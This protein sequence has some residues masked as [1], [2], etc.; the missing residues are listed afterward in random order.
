MRGV[1]VGMGL[2]LGVSLS[3]LT[4]A[5]APRGKSSREA[6]QA[7]N[8]L[9]G[10]WQGTGTPAGTRAEQQRGFWTEKIAWQWQF[11]DKDAWLGVV[12]TGG[13]HFSRGGLRYVPGDDTF[14][15]T[16]ETPASETRTFTGRLKDHV[17]TLQNRDK[18][19]KE[20][21]Q[22]V[23]T[24][25]HENRFLYRYEVKADGRP[26]FSRFFTVGAKRDGVPFAAGDGRPECVVSG[27][28]GTIAVVYRGTTYY[29]CCSG[30]RDEFKENPEKYIK[31]F[32]E[33]KAK[34]A[35]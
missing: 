11:K 13:K 34:A 30:C 4:P 35:K 24:L 26:L 15:L 22:V 19:K 6:L 33:R 3:S 17:L 18:S 25:L 32:Q 21:Q 23:L 9:I 7:F 20:T 10:A 8:D 29:V 14:Q 31:E 2:L 1:C 5:D 28:L 12:F 27:G 16:V